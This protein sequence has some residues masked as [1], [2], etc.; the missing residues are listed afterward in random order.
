[1]EERASMNTGQVNIVANSLSSP[2][3]EAVLPNANT[4]CELVIRP[5]PG[6]IAIDWSELYRYRELLYFLTWRDVSV[7][8]KQTVLGVAWAVL[9]PLFNMVVFTVVFGNFANMPSQGAPYAVF[10]YAALLPW[11]FFASGVS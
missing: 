11:M 3:V 6:W 8:Y 5:R 1:M 10:V 2:V 4:P 7:R 9:Q